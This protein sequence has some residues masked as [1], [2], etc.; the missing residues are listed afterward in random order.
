MRGI[1]VISLFLLLLAGCVGEGVKPVP[2]IEYFNAT[3]DV[4]YKGDSAILSWRVVNTTNKTIVALD[5]VQVEPEGSK[6]VTPE[7]TTNY[8]LSVDG[9]NKTIS[10]IVLPAEEADRDKD[11]YRVTEDCDDNNKAVYPGA[12]EKC[13]GIDDDC[14]GSKD[15]ENAEGCVEYYLDVD[16]DSYGSV[17]KCLCGPDGAYTAR[18]GWDCDD[19]DKT[20]SPLAIEVCDGKDNNCDNKTDDGENL[21]GCLRFYIDEDNDGYGIGMG[22]CL[23]MAYDVYRAKQSGDCDDTDDDINPGA[24]EKCNG[25]DDNCD[26]KVDEENAIG[27]KYYYKDVD[28][29]GYG[30]NKKKC[31]CSASEEYKAENDDDCDDTN[32]SINP[33]KTE[34]CNGIDDDCDGQVDE[35]LNDKYEPNNNIGSAKLLSGSNG[36][37][38]GKILK[39][40]DDYYKVRVADI[41]GNITGSAEL[42]VPAGVDFDLC[43]CWSSNISSCN[44]VEWDCS[45]HEA[46]EDESIAALVEGGSGEAYFI[47]R[48]LPV[49]NAWSCEEYGLSW[50]V[51]G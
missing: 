12:V 10:V 26:G 14:D 22:K 33:G 16:Q 41:S 32:K 7:K 49:G 31:L 45:E 18:R 3:P 39:G 35:G 1:I 4:I 46:G 30:I 42:R 11:G 5:M 13:N 21:Q 34:V 19:S 6:T 27:C 17:M 29:D 37:L 20:I 47:L 43:V 9:K 2:E 51:G 25:K 48:V 50:S 40:D 24:N 15:E 38:E 8:T 28:G 44:L 36:D 23:C